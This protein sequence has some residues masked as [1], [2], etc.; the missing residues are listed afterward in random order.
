ML[1]SVP[2]T[3]IV[4]LLTGWIVA[5][6]VRFAPRLRAAGFVEAGSQT[7]SSDVWLPPPDGRCASPENRSLPPARKINA[8]IVDDARTT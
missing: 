5:P 2:S 6:E 1:T 8:S 4:L 3:A 7:V